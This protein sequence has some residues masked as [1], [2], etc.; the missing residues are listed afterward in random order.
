VYLV[1]VWFNRSTGIKSRGR[2]GINAALNAM[3]LVNPWL[4]D[5]VDKS[6]LI[7]GLKEIVSTVSQGNWCRPIAACYSPRPVPGLVMITPDNTTTIDAYGM[8]P[9]S[10]THCH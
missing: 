2:L 5:P 6:T 3:P 10:R 4:V 8:S 9:R 7:A 1:R